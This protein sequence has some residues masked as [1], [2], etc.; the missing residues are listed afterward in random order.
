MNV[1]RVET[2]RGARVRVL[3]A[4]SGAPL[5]FLH[6]A[7]GFLHENPFL[8]ELATRYPRLRARAARLRRVDGRGAARGHARL[9]APRLG[10]GGGARLERPHLVGHSWAA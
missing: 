9:R 8:D 1:K 2:K 7:G 4:G 10:R 3:E 6:G 5:V